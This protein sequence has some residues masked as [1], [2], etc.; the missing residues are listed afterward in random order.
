MPLPVDARLLSVPDCDPEEMRFEAA[1]A[2]ALLVVRESRALADRVAP[3]RVL[4]VEG[5]RPGL[6]GGPME[7]LVVVVVARA[8][9]DAA[10]AP[11]RVFAGV[12]VR[13]VAVLDAAVLP[14]PSCLVGDFVGD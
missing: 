1:A 7:L 13:D 3:P 6:A 14:R 11:P 2:G 12:P 4:D 8:L 10:T 9:A 5:W